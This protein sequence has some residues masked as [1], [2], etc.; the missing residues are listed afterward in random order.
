MQFSLTFD[1]KGRCNAVQCENELT[2]F[3]EVLKDRFNETRLQRIL[4]VTSGDRVHS[5]DD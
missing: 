1:T 2:F 5:S 4:S 3:N